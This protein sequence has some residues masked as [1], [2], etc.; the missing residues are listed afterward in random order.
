MIREEYPACDGKGRLGAWIVTRG[1]KHGCGASYQGMKPCGRRACVI[2][3]HSSTCRVVCLTAQYG[4]VPLCRTD[5]IPFPPSV[6]KMCV[7]IG[8][9][10]MWE[11]LCSRHA[12][13]RM[14]V[15]I[16]DTVLRRALHRVRE[17][18]LAYGRDG[19]R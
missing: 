7:R 10:G 11:T 8:N 12:H 9:A 1:K 6:W 13:G 17:Q 5:R 4:S 19:L 2:V 14:F 16:V 18:V 15:L 3:G